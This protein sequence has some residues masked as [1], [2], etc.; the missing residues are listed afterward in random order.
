MRDR[1]V[2]SIAVSAQT[3]LVPSGGGVGVRFQPPETADRPAG[4]STTSFELAKI[5][6]VEG[7]A[8]R[9]LYA[10]LEDKQRLCGLEP[11]SAFEGGGELIAELGK[12]LVDTGGWS[13]ASLAEAATR[14]VA[15]ERKLA[16]AAV[17]GRAAEPIRAYR[18]AIGSL[19]EL[20]KELRGKPRPVGGDVL[21]LAAAL[22]ATT[23]A[24]A[25]I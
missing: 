9:S 21:R 16:A 24:A 7:A 22:D 6:S 1:V 14:I 19:G 15:L 8:P 18:E 3:Y 10:V 20:A 4:L 12:L 13:V 2:S 17:R 25:A 5:P 11:W 23:R